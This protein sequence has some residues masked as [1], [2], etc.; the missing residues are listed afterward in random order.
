MPRVKGNVTPVMSFKIGAS[1]AVDFGSEVVSVEFTDGDGNNVTFSDYAAGTP[2]QLN[3]TLV[4]DFAANSSYEF[5]Y[6][7]SN[8]SNVTYVYQPASAAASQTNPK[9]TG[10]LALPATKPRFSVEAGEATDVATYEMSFNLDSFTK[11]I[12]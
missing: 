2:T 8:A 10:T 9:F 11:A 5:F 3:L 12:S 6:A 1:S 4:L 7:N